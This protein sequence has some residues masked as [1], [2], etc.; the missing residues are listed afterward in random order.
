MKTRQKPPRK[1]SSV[2][3]W[4]KRQQRNL[5]ILTL[6]WKLSEKN[7]KKIERKCRQSSKLN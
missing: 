3:R 6:R 1:K 7:K 4:K 5:E 2:R